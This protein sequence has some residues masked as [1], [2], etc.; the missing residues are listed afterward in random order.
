MQHNHSPS[1]LQDG[2]NFQKETVTL[3]IEV[4]RIV[5]INEELENI[6]RANAAAI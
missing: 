1:L 6:L 3:H 5:F 4:D 2:E